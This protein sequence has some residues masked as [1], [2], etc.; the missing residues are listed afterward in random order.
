MIDPTLYLV[1]NPEQC[2]N[3]DA[4]ATA[5]DAARGGVTA[6][7]IRCK[8]HAE[9]EI[10]ALV[11]EAAL[12]LAEFNVPVIVND[13]VSVAAKSEAAGVHV[14]QQD[15]H[16][17]QVRKV[18]GADA[19][20]GVTVRSSKEVLNTPLEQVD[21]VSVGGVFPTVSKASSE[22]PIGIERLRE[23]VQLVKQN[24]PEMPVI[25]ISGINGDNLDA[26]LNT[27]V[28]GVA[29]VSAICESDSPK[30]AARQLKDHIEAYNL[31]N[32]A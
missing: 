23:I 4:V 14:G 10:Y 12:R 25:A 18:L 20:I 3:R 26:V 13:D 8:N 2:V 24:A 9:E 27:G 32:S 16:V 11:A 21:Y 17:S 28:C 5:V 31:R 22:Q 15:T 30:I 1:V 19:C 6:V 29:V 7:Q